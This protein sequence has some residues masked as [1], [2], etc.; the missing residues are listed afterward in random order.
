[1][2]L[3]DRG[4]DWQAET[5]RALLFAGVVGWY[6]MGMTAFSCLVRGLMAH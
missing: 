1:M 5:D 2:N 4:T 3:A 6:G